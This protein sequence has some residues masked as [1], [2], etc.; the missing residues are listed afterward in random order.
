MQ[1][2]LAIPAASAE[3]RVQV[4]AHALLFPSSL[5]VTQ[6]YSEISIYCFTNN[7]FSSLYLLWVTKSFT[8][9]NDY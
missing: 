5:M 6:S 1:Q 2:P 4:T 3:E 9:M 7:Y 8:T